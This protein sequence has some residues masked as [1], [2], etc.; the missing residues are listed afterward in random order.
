MKNQV[1]S[2]RQFRSKLK[3]ERN[4]IYRPI[5][6]EGL[7]P[8]KPTQIFDMNREGDEFCEWIVRTLKDGGGFVLGAAS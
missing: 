4:L 1:S 6:Q 3:H 5:V 2:D 7:L 8:A